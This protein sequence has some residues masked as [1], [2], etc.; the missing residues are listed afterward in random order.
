QLK[1]EMQGLGSLVLAVAEQHAVPGGE[2]LCVDRNAFGKAITETLENHELIEVH[3]EEVT[4]ALIEGWLGVGDLVVL[5]TG[6]LT[7]PA[8]SEWLAKQTGRRH[9]YFYDAVSPTVEA[10]SLDRSIVFAE[11]RY[12]KGEGDDYLNCP[13]NKENYEAF[14]AELVAAERAPFHA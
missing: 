1:G 14:V 3:R 2:A 4:P 13:F 10:A 11:S 8:V 6:P 7:S 12:G 9:L 5:A